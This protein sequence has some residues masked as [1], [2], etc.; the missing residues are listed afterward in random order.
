MSPRRR[1]LVAVLLALLLVGGGI[2]GVRLVRSAE[3][4]VDPVARVA[5][6]TKKLLPKHPK[7]PAR[8]PAVAVNAVAAPVPT[9]R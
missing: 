9:R 2:A 6:R 1:L 3:P 7:P 5:A 4:A 8:P